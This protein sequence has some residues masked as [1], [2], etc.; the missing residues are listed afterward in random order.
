MPKKHHT[1]RLY[2]VRKKALKKFIDG[3][4]LSKTQEQRMAFVIGFN[5]GYK[6][7][8]KHVL[9]PKIQK[10]KWKPI[11]YALCRFKDPISFNQA[12]KLLKC[13]E[14]ALQKHLDNYEYVPNHKDFHYSRRMDITDD[15]DNMR[16]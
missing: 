8:R 14:K 9:D 16:F 11:L 15:L 2:N 7:G 4:V 10:S 12:L 6:Q 5:M 1:K 13:T 3:S